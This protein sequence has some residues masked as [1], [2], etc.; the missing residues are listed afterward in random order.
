MELGVTWF[1]TN[2]AGPGATTLIDAR[3]EFNKMNR[4]A[5]LW[6]VH[7][8]WPAGPVLLSTTT[9]IGRSFYS[10]NLSIRQ[11]RC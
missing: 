2:E 6:T 7:H 4:L 8:H 10:A 11:L 3:N 1:L 9:N 5:M